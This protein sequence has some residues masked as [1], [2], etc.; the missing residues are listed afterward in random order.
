M[1]TIAPDALP[2]AR[3]LEFGP[4]TFVT[5]AAIVGDVKSG[6]GAALR[7]HAERLGDVE[8]GQPLWI[9]REQ[10]TASLDSLPADQ[11][12]LLHRVADRIRAFA[13]MQKSCLKEGELQH[14]GM[15]AGH[16]IAPIE[17]V[18][19]YAPGGRFP[20]PSSALMTAVTAK[21]AGVREVFLA[22]PHPAPI[23]LAAAA[24]AGAD[25]LLAAGGAQAI[26][27]LA[28]GAG[29]QKP[30]DMV[31]GPGNRYVTAAKKLVSGDVGIDFLAGPSELVVLADEQADPD[32]VAAD[33]LAQ[34]E[35][36]DDALPVLV[37]DSRELIDAVNAELE[38]QLADLPTADTAHN[39]LDNGFAVLCRDLQQ[40][41]TV[42][43][44]LA[45]EH[46]ALH[47]LEPN[48]IASE[49]NHYGALFLGESSAEVFG[50]YGTGPN[51]VLP[52][53]GVARFSGGLSVFTFLRI[54]TW[55][56]CQDAGDSSQLATDTS[57][58]ARLEGLEAHARS[59]ERRLSS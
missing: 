48:A 28:Y 30:C 14:D 55:I 45:P 32:L 57:S 19:C 13:E 54:R 58:F 31:V 18:G 33:L 5:V 53:G 35:H 26:A 10:L 2:L 51:H 21:V 42:C 50:D 29:H 17:R 22:S 25:G 20:L 11:Q 7:R 12:Q 39:A 59:A 41:C 15:A 24:V 49:L 56:R 27:A 37:T 46:L 40:G 4:D 1:R 47:V 52:T 38:T 36:D 8:T 23:T 43:D 6:G 16:S 9:T 34:A 44:R 3:R